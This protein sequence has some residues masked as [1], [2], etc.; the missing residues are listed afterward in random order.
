MIHF[1][2][3]PHTGNESEYIIEAIASKKIAGDGSFTKRCNR[4]LEAK[5]GSPKALLT[6]SGTHVGEMS[7][8]LADIK[9]GDEVIMLIHLCLYGKCL[10]FA[11]SN[12]RV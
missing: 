5:T 12:D 1:N 2:V 7:A 3:P 8:L 4:W 6:T 9:P 10:R 11:G